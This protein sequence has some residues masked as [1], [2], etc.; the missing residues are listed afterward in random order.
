MLDQ[1]RLTLRIQ[2]I[3]PATSRLSLAKASSSKNVKTKEHKQAKYKIS[4]ATLWLLRKYQCFKIHTFQLPF[5]F[6]CQSPS[7]LPTIPGDQYESGVYVQLLFL[8]LILETS[9]GRFLEFL[10]PMR[11]VSFKKRLCQQNRH[12]K[13]LASAFSLEK[14]NVLPWLLNPSL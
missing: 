11:N 4:L 10:W 2:S 3:S 7:R 12:F 1:F 9:E 6:P 14:N 8:H 5:P 13:C